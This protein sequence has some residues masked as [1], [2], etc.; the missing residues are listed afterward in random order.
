MAAFEI[1]PRIATEI[2]GAISGSHCSC[3][4][5]MKHVVMLHQMTHNYRTH[6]I[7]EANDFYT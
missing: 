7:I 3:A 5:G 4:D 1:M 6:L 2:C